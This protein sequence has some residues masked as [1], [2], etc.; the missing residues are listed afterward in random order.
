LG[1]LPNF[2]SQ[3]L[4]NRQSFRDK[5]IPSKLSFTEEMEKI[6]SFGKEMT[7]TSLTWGAWLTVCKQMLPSQGLH[8]NFHSLHTCKI[9]RIVEV[10]SAILQLEN[11][12]P[13]SYQVP[14]QL[15]GPI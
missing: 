8:H 15:P 10:F 4:N 12:Q 1:G 11:H 2:C 14:N 9:T 7:W 13:F 5:Q 6:I 3:C